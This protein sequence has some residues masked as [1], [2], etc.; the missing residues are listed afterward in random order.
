MEH[1][2]WVKLHRK[3]LEN[4]VFLYDDT[5]WKIFTICLL[6]A[7]HATGKLT[8]GSNQLSKLSG[9]ER[10]VCH[11]ALKRLEKHEMVQLTAQRN[12]TRVLICN[13]HKHQSDTQRVAQRRRNA[14]ATQTHTLQEKEKEKEDIYTELRQHYNQTFKKKTTSN[15]PFSKLVDYWLTIYSLDDIKAAITNAAA[16]P[17]WKDKLTLVMFLRTK[18]KQGQPVDHICDLMERKKT[19]VTKYL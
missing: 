9:K 6:L 12:F 15:I 11:R 2:W 17:W 5:A 3:T 8:I 1:K 18:D 13:W 10:S 16:D 7:D 4:E 14:D 19:K